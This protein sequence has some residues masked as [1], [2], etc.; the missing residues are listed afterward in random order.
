MNAA[1]YCCCQEEPFACGPDLVECGAIVGFVDSMFGDIK[2][3]DG[4]VCADSF[5]V[6]TGWPA[7]WDGV[8]DNFVNVGGL[9]DTW[10]VG[11]NPATPLGRQFIP[12]VTPAN[13][14]VEVIRGDGGS[15]IGCKEND[16]G[17]PAGGYHFIRMVIGGDGVPPGR[18]VAY[19][20]KG[21]GSTKVGIYTL[22]TSLPANWGSW[23]QGLAPTATDAGCYI[24]IPNTIEIADC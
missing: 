2:F 24:P 9:G 19:W 15:L 7:Y 5:F 6:S 1:M 4:A 11:A 20:V 22:A 17:Q 23:P 21:T 3:W 13:R 12:V 18:Y 10:Q 8:F 16:V 14:M